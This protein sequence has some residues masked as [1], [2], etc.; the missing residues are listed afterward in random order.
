MTVSGEI[1]KI[2][3]DLAKRFGVAIDWSATN[4]VPYLED[5]CGRYIKYEIAMN[6]AWCVLFFI[7]GTI[8]FIWLCKRKDS[9]V[10]KCEY[11]D[12]N[13]YTGRI[14]L[15]VL[16]VGL[17]MFIVIKNLFDI[18]PCVFLPEKIIIEELR[19]IYNSFSN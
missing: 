9:G 12:Y 18:I 5:L 7:V 14:F 6:V 19:H 4:V 1:T 16:L 2:L 11:G 13:D 8:G 3:D 15:Y 17:P 10:S